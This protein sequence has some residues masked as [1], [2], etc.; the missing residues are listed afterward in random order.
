MALGGTLSEW[1]TLAALV[2][3]PGLAAAVL[4]TPVLAAGRLRALFRELP[5]TRRTPVNY[6]VAALALA[7]PWV[8][9][10]GWAFATIGGALESAQS[11]DP[12]VDVAVQL[13]GLYVVAL[14]VLAVAGLPALG[15]DWDPTG[16]GASTWVLLVAASAYYAAIFAIPAAAMGILFSL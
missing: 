9:G 14:P 12:L 13:S 16:Y 6:A 2:L 15:V 5:L 8:L 11:G 1:G 10:F 7:V 3:G 4:W